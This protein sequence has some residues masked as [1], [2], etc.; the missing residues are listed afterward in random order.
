M[1]LGD[2]AVQLRWQAQSSSLGVTSGLAEIVPDM[3]AIPAIVGRC[4]EKMRLQEQFNGDGDGVKGRI[5]PAQI[6]RPV[7]AIEAHCGI[8]QEGVGQRDVR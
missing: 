4:S 7:S 8:A 5:A 2:D 6:R 1:K 3:A